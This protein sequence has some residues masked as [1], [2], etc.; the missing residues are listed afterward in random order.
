MT[1]DRK[2]NGLNLIDDSITA[3]PPLARSPPRPVD[4]SASWRSPPNKAMNIHSFRLLQRPDPSRAAKVVL[5]KWLYTDAMTNP[6]AVSMSAI[7]T[8]STR[9]SKKP[10]SPSPPELRGNGAPDRIY[11]WR[12]VTSPASRRRHR[13]PGTHRTRKGE[14]KCLVD[15]LKANLSVRAVS[16]QCSSL[17]VLGVRPRTGQQ[18]DEH[19]RST[20]HPGSSRSAYHRPGSTTRRPHLRHGYQ[21]WRHRRPQHLDGSLGRLRV[22]TAHAGRHVPG[23]DSDSRQCLAFPRGRHAS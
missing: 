7:Y 23:L 11:T 6:R 19:V 10:S 12:T 1:E 18:P 8:S 3:W 16:S 9:W 2:C 15:T 14:Q 20:C 4:G 21:G 13:K 17:S 5:S 22:I